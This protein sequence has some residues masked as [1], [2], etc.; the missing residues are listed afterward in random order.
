MNFLV[1]EGEPEGVM[2]IFHAI[3]KTSVA[4]TKSYSKTDQHG[5]DFSLLIV[6]F[7]VGLTKVDILTSLNNRLD[8]RFGRSLKSIDNGVIEVLKYKNTTITFCSQDSNYD[9]LIKAN[10]KIN[11]RFS[12]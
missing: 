10:E 2:F 5:F 9:I 1:L 3:D 7:E 6:G 11:E 8:Q 12:N 4:A